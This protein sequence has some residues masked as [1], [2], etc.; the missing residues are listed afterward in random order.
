MAITLLIRQMRRRKRY[1]P[2]LGSRK[3][4]ANKNCVT[5]LGA[6]LHPTVY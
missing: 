3:E 5:A 1:G 4:R 6:F 2:T